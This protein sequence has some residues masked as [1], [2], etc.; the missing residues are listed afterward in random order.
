MIDNTYPVTIDQEPVTHVD[1]HSWLL[2]A[3]DI[4]DRLARQNRSRELALVGTK[5]EEAEMW[6]LK[7]LANIPDTEVTV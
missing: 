4:T 5:L 2:G 6:L 1:L 7:E 3:I